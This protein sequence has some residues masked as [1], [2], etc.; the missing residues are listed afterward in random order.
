MWAFPAVL[1]PLLPCMQGPEHP[2]P[3][4]K[5]LQNEHC[6][7]KELGQAPFPHS[8][9][10]ARS[11]AAGVSAGEQQPAWKVRGQLLHATKQSPY[12]WH[13]GRK[14][15]RGYIGKLV[16]GMH[17][18][19]H[20]SL[21][22]SAWDLLQKSSSAFLARLILHNTYSVSGMLLAPHSPLVHS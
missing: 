17:G 11:P 12:S 15:R 8:A 2:D 1:R 10:L 18:S 16:E 5:H 20:A 21:Y 3:H 6:H 7:C 4:L 13:E 14:G 9:L 22:A 19:A